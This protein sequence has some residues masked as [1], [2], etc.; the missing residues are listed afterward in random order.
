M[1]EIHSTVLSIKNNKA[2]GPNTK[3]TEFLKVFFKTLLLIMI[4]IKK[5]ILFHM[6]K[7]SIFMI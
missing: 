2:P 1:S 4:L 3:T 6:C 5:L 7:M